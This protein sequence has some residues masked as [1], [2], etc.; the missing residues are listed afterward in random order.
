MEINILNTDWRVDDKPIYTPAKDTKIEYESYAASESG[1][2]E[3][4]IM[5][6]AW[7][8]RQMV[9]VNL[10][11]PVMTKSEAAYLLGLLQGKEFSFTYPDPVLGSRT[12]QAYASNSNYDFYS[13]VVNGGLLTNV[14]INI[15]E[16]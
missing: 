7:I 4:G 13:D 14:S 15:I 3:D 9:K 2:T 12:I 6:I 10:V 5:H 8:R 16:K 1:R 11:Y